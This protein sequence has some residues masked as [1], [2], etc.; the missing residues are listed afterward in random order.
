MNTTSVP[1]N[2][3]RHA[4]LGLILAGLSIGTTGCTA[5]ALETVKLAKEDRLTHDH[6]VDTQIGM[7]IASG[8]Y[9]KDRNLARAVNAD[10]WELQ[11]L[12]TGI[13]AD[14]KT[15]QSVM[16]TVRTDARIKKIYD[17][18]QIVPAGS[19]ARTEPVEKVEEMPTGVEADRLVSD[20]WIETK[21][22]AQLITARDISS[23][24][25][26]WRSVRNTVYLLGRAQSDTELKAVI[27]IIAATKGVQQVKPFVEIRPTSTQTAKL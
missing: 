26:R 14:A 25:Y 9:E 13:V 1:E 20:F 12:M 10:V 7:A 6:L 19:E 15:R 24:N 22:S 17:E 11:V 18:I 4:L 3:A 5:L 23:V 27:D 21:I 2:F 16:Q 8:L